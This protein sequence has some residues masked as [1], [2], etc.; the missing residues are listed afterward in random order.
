MPKFMLTE[1]FI[2]EIFCK[3]DDEMKDVPKHSQSKFYPSEIATS[4]MDIKIHG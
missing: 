2:I 3:I 4:K 1:D